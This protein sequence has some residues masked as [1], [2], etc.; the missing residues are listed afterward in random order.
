M[1]LCTH[2]ESARWERSLLR[3]WALLMTGHSHHHQVF[4]VRVPP[5]VRVPRRIQPQ[6]KAVI[7]ATQG[8]RVY[9]QDAPKSWACQRYKQLVQQPQQS[10]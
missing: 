4:V 10:R 3:R 5:I 2:A 9:M 8:L 6:A 1:T 7:T